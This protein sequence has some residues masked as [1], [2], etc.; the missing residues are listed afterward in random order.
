MSMSR[1]NITETCLPILSFTT[2]VKEIV[3]DLV[4]ENPCSIT[5]NTVLKDVSDGLQSCFI[6]AF[7]Q[8]IHGNVANRVPPEL[9]AYALRQLYKS[10]AYRHTFRLPCKSWNDV[11][12]PGKARG[13]EILGLYVV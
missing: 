3:Y 13:F 8:C 10:I 1:F 2:A 7:I 4:S 5:C 12:A 6:Q 9:C 11:S